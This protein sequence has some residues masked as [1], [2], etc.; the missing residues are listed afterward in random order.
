M[1]EPCQIRKN[2]FG[3]IVKTLKENNFRLTSPG[4]VFSES[5]PLLQT[6]AEKGKMVIYGLTLK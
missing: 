4:V 5:H 2:R 3:A 6:P 1:D